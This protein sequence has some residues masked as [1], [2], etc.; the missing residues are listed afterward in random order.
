MAEPVHSITD[1]PLKH[2][3]EQ[4][5]RMLRYT[6]AMS[7]RIICF[8]LAV[9]VGVVWETW[10]AMAFVAAAVVLPYVAVV[11]ANTDGDRYMASRAADGLNAQPQ[12]TTGPSA[13]E[14]A[15]QPQWWEAEAEDYDHGHFPGA[16]DV[17]S[18][19]VI[20][21]EDLTDQTETD[22]YPSERRKS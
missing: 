1:A 19:E 15:E 8:I 13:D 21:G 5:G 2:S 7:I 11:D 14:A 9:G 4:H 16:G 12:L 17:I 18:G 20:T 6:L 3:E 10:W 22:T